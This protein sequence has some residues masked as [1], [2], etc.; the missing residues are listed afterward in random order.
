MIILERVER[1]DR[2]FLLHRRPSY[3]PRQNSTIFSCQQQLTALRSFTTKIDEMEFRTTP[4]S[5]KPQRLRAYQIETSTI[6]GL[7]SLVRYPSSSRTFNTWYPSAVL[8]VFSSVLAIVCKEYI[9]YHPPLDP[10]KMKSIRCQSDGSFGGVNPVQVANV[11]ETRLFG[12]LPRRST[13]WKLEIGSSV[14]N[15]SVNS[16]LISATMSLEPVAIS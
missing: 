11:F 15:F 2:Q 1:E 14:E 9:T 7:W 4:P 5:S 10:P 8:H 16:E 6:T 12:A 3:A 13:R